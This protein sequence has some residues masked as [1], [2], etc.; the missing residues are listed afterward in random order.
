MT[1]ENRMSIVDLLT[2]LI[3]SGNCPEIVLAAIADAPP[4]EYLSAAT[5]DLI[6]A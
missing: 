3:I 6:A 4:V 5:V 2:K 1:K